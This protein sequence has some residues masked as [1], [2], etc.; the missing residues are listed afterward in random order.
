MR[1]SRSAKGFR[2]FALVAG[3]AFAAPALAGDTE[4][5]T[6]PVFSIGPG[7]VFI[8]WVPGASSTLVRTKNG[9]SVVLTTSMLPA[10]HAVTMWALIFN[11]PSACGEGGC[12]EIRGDLRNPDVLGSVQRITGHVVGTEGA[13]AGH[14]AL[15]EAS[16][17]AF[18]PG[19]LDPFGAE[20]H[21]IVREHGVASPDILLDQFH[22][23][24]PRFCN[25]SCS[26]IQKSVHLPHE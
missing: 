10:G 14:L 24:S 21:L 26:D 2:L 18:G 19:L 5:G 11:N 20:I 17:T 25:V 8:D 16:S 1:R 9:I 23:D 22:N 13:F 12:D 7:H 15:D 6:S 4:V 3:L